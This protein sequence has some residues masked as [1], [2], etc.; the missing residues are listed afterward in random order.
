MTIGLGMPT[1]GSG[2]AEF[3]LRRARSLARFFKQ[4]FQPRRDFI[5]HRVGLDAGAASRSFD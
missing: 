4:G 1:V 3:S 5:H 2:F